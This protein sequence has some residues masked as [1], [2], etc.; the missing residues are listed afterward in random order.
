MYD[1]GAPLEGHLVLYKSVLHNPGNTLPL[2]FLE[3]IALYTSMRNRCEYS[4]THHFMNVRGLL[5]DN[6]HADTIYAALQA[7][8]SEDAFDGKH[9][10]LLRY[11][12]KLTSNVGEMQ[13]QDIVAL[14]ETGADDGEILEVN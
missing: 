5:P 4:V 14:H 6:G 13:E 9:L 3:T 11:A 7:D 1:L 10:A 12:A 8:R 2:W